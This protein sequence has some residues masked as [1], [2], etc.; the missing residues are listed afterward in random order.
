M[1]SI[2]FCQ[3][4]GRQLERLEQTY[5]VVEDSAAEVHPTKTT[6]QALYGD[7]RIHDILSGL[8]LVLRHNLRLEVT[9]SILRRLDGNC[10]HARLQYIGLVAV[11]DIVYL[12]E[13]LLFTQSL[14]FLSSIFCPL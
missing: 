14:A 9:V 2:P 8:G 6:V 11:L 3:L 12:N 7:G 5:G 10:S 13:L 1:G 4:P